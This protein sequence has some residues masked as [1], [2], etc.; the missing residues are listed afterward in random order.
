MVS[1]TCSSVVFVTSFSVKLAR[2]VLTMSSSPRLSLETVPSQS[3][4]SS[5][6]SGVT[7]VVKP[8]L[9]VARHSYV[10]VSPTGMVSSPMI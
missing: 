9:Y 7:A 10:A 1:V 4:S 2:S 3:L 5:V 6:H 8:L